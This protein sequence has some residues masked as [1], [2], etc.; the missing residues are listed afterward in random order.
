MFK[1]KSFSSPNPISIKFSLDG[2]PISP[3]TYAVSNF[4]PLFGNIYDFSIKIFRLSSATATWNYTFLGN[5]GNIIVA[6]ATPIAC[7]FTANMNLNIDIQ[8]TGTQ[9]VG[10][11]NLVNYNILSY[12]Q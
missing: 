5:A 2:T 9:V 11:F 12:R 8:K 4:V 1:G 10:D 3:L 7:D 6:S